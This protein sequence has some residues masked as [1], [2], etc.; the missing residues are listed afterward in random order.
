MIP[1]LPYRV[2]AVDPA[3]GKSGWAVVD[4]LSVQPLRIRIIAHGLLEGDKLLRT[5]KEMAELYPR[6]FC[7]LDA[8][9]DEYERLIK[10]YKPDRVASES[11]FGYVHMSAFMSLTLAINTLRRVSAKLL[12]KDIM[13]VPPTITKAAF[14][15]RG[16]ADKDLM[17][18]A[19]QTNPYLENKVEDGNLISEHEI[20]AIGHSI[21]HIKRD[22][23]QT[24][25]QVSA[26]DKKRQKLER[27][28]AKQLADLQKQKIIGIG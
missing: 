6:Q 27:K 1:D 20:D 25:N 13:E 9:Y 14:T 26:K 5:K 19:Y 12:N 24:I 18:L 28:K 21:G 4:L 2:F 11:A 15:G 10:L 17:R 7:V 8:L 22:I 16:G 3:T 23:L